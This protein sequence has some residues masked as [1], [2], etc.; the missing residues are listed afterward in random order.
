MPFARTANYEIEKDN[1]QF[2]V[3]RDCGPHDEYPT[4]TNAAES[5]VDFLHKNLDRTLS[6][7]RLFY[8]DSGGDFTEL[9]HHSGKF[10]DYGP[11]S[12]ALLELVESSR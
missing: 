11:V 1:D 8:W 6:G 2:V 10:F 9:I 5:V 4:V 3:I 12:V 7:R